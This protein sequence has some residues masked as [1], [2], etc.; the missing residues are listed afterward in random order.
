MT[1]P[2][3]GA[4]IVGSSLA[5]LTTYLLGPIFG[6]YAIVLGMGLLGTLAA[7]ADETFDDQGI[8]WTHSVW[9]AVKFLFRG[10][11]LSFAFGSV[12]TLFALHFIP[13]DIGVTPYAALSAVSFAIGWS[14]NRL[15]AL[16]TRV[17]ELI[18]RFFR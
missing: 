6:E 10:I 11:A 13:S 16:R 17:L 7:L 12:L 14:S 4:L 8:G 9:L 1:E 5:T 2:S 18:G 3:S 15:G